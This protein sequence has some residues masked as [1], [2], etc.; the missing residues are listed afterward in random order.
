MMEWEFCYGIHEQLLKVLILDVSTKLLLYFHIN[1]NYTYIILVI[2]NR[3]SS[4]IL[5]YKENPKK[6]ILPE[7]DTKD[8]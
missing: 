1:C 2:H 5:S 7:N 3:G 6:C 8:L 4:V